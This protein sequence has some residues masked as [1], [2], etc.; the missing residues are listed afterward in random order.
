MPGSSA[1]HLIWFIAAITVA[2]AVVSALTA[3]VMEVTEGLEERTDTL[4]GELRADVE[5]V[6]DPLMVPYE[7]GTSTL[8]VYIKN[9]GSESLDV[10]PDTLLVFVNGSAT[11]ADSVTVLGGSSLWAPGVT[12]EA[13][14]TV[15]GLTEGSY[16]YMKV[17]ASQY[18]GVHDSVDFMVT[19]I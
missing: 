17:A 9:T 11:P 14:F 2:V 6:N 5:I 10:N 8:H 15:A 3:T 12:V 18:H 19:Y 7:Q 1:S 4:S 13:E 16:Y